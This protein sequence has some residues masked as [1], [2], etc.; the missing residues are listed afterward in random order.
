[1]KA[2]IVEKSVTKAIDPNVSTVGCSRK[3]VEYS[4]AIAG[5]PR[6]VPRVINRH[7]IRVFNELWYH[8]APKRRRDELQSI[9]T[10]FHPLDI[11]AEWNRVYGPNGFLQYQFVVPFSAH[12]TFKRCFELIVNFNHPYIAHSP[13]DFWRRWHISLSTWF[14]DY[15][16]IP[17]GG[18][19]VA[20]PQRETNLVATFLLSGLWHGASWN[21]VL[22]GL[23]HGTLLVLTRALG[24][25]LRLP[26]KWP[27][28]LALVQVALTFVLMMGGWLFFREREITDKVIAASVMFCGV[29]IL[30]LPLDLTAS[31][32]M[33]VAMV[34][35]WRT[36][37]RV[38]L[39]YAIGM[40]AFLLLGP[41]TGL[42]GF[43]PAP[44]TGP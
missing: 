15:V 4:H 10:F 29:L 39:V 26:E 41:P 22:W 32:L 40:P 35:E 6:A 19:R 31:L 2:T 25:A 43:T 7:T 1:M 33:V 44:V 38:S 14:R 24:T 20:S 42:I 28:P 21:F 8:K 3:P 5:T 9:T 30:Y 11:V 16:Y 12:E 27:G 13:T 37:G 17:L 23:Y 36:R 18:S 34:F